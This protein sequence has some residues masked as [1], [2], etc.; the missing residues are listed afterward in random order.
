MQGTQYHRVLEISIRRFLEFVLGNPQGSCYNGGM[1]KPISIP[2]NKRQKSIIVG[3]ILGDGYLEYGGFHG[4]RLQIKQKED[5]REYI[6]WL[7]KELHNLCFSPPKQKSDNNQWYVATRFLVEL[8]SL[9][10][11]FYPK[12]KKEI[13]EN[14]SDLIISPL[15]LAVWYMDDG[16][17]DWRPKS[18]YAFLISADSFSLAGATR[19]KKML[20]KNFGVKAKVYMPFSRQKRYPKIYIGREGRDR[21]LQLI[22]PYILKSFSYKLPPL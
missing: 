13:P 7:Y 9:Y 8:T 22:K 16:S 4:T 19:L 3:S 21:F 15:T 14:I 12:G 6:F 10:Q 17:L 5:R 11:T 18:H 20:R 1:R 2:I